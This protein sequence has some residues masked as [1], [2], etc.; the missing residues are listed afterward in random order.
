MTEEEQIEF[1]TL[2]RRI[3]ELERLASDLREALSKAN[4]PQEDGH[5]EFSY[6]DSE[7]SMNET[8]VYDYVEKRIAEEA[9]RFSIT[10]S[11][12]VE[13]GGGGFNWSIQIKDKAA[14]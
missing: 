6:T 12:D 2:Q 8:E 7:H 11:G 5:T 13:V 9:A 3:S 4:S 1:A 10:G 14:K